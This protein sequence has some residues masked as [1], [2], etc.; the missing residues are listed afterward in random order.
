MKNN[1]LYRVNLCAHCG[2]FLSHAPRLPQALKQLNLLPVKHFK[3]TGDIK[4]CLFRV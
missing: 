1:I 4:S 3:R 2:M